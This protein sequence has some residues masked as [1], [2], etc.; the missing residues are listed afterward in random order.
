MQAMHLTLARD[1]ID[2]DDTAQVS[3]DSAQPGNL[4]SKP[5]K[6]L[7]EGV[8]RLEWT[9]LSFHQSPSILLS[10]PIAYYPRKY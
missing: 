10:I 6:G 8:N 5:W 2:D 4:T 7:A 3:R 1:A 9:A